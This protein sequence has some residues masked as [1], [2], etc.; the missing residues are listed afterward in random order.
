[1]A[2]KITAT[3]SL[4]AD[5]EEVTYL[6][7]ELRKL[8]TKYADHGTCRSSRTEATRMLAA[9]IKAGQAFQEVVHAEGRAEDAAESYEVQA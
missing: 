7:A 5:T 4:T 6:I 8:A 1:M 9:V 3:G 2:E